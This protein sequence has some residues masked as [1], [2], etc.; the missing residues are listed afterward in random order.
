MIRK[1]VVEVPLSG[2][3][4]VGIRGGKTGWGGAGVARG[5][6]PGRTDGDAGSSRD[7]D[8]GRIG[9]VGAGASRR[10]GAGRRGRGGGSP[11]IR[12][13]RWDQGGDPWRIGGSGRGRLGAGS[14]WGSGE[15]RWCGSVS[16]RDRSGEPGRIGGVGAGFRGGQERVVR[17][18]GEPYSVPV[19]DG[20]GHDRVQGRDGTRE[21]LDVDDDPEAA[22]LPD[23]VVSGRDV[24]GMDASSRPL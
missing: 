19:V 9:G 5:G 3:G 21:S 4:G 15:D 10:S 14:K 2:R 6:V 18:S 16:G 24:R 7:G 22:H 13:D 17:G 23:N 1:R 8:P 11:G 12:T 20:T